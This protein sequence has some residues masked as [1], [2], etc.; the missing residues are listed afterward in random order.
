MTLARKLSL[1][2]GNSTG[3]DLINYPLKS[4]E[5]LLERK[6]VKT[7]KIAGKEALELEIDGSGLLEFSGVTAQRVYTFALKNKLGKTLCFGIKDHRFFLDRSRS[8]QTD[9]QEHFA[10][11]AQEMMMKDLPKDS[12]ELRFFLD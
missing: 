2:K 4:V 1:R 12:Y 6:A 10:N 8:G 9:F 3:Y 5:K 7:L 11:K